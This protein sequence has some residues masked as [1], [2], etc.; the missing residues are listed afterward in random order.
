MHIIEPRNV[1]FSCMAPN[2]PVQWSYMSVCW[3]SDARGLHRAYP[4]FQCLYFL[5][6]IVLMK[7][8]HQYR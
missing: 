6:R 1:M 3:G 5:R 8:K 4:G 2:R 7:C